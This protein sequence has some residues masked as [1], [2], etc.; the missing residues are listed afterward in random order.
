MQRPVAPHAITA[1]HM[2]PPLPASLQ[3]LSGWRRQS[4]GC[5]HQWRVR[6]Q[7]QVRCCR[8]SQRQ[9]FGPACLATVLQ[10]CCP[11]LSLPGSMPVG[12]RRLLL[13]FPMLP[14]VPG[15]VATASRS[16]LQIS[17]DG[18]AAQVRWLALRVLW[19]QVRLAGRAALSSLT[20]P[21]ACKPAAPQL[22]AAT[23]LAPL[24]PPLQFNRTK[25]CVDGCSCKSLQLRGP[26]ALKPHPAGHPPAHPPLVLL[27][28]VRVWVD[29]VP[30][31]GGDHLEGPPSGVA[32]GGSLSPPAS[33]LPETVQASS[34]PATCPCA[35]PPAAWHRLQLRVGAFWPDVQADA[36]QN[37]FQRR[38]AVAT[39]VH[40]SYRARRYD[41]ALFLLDEPS[42]N[43]RVSLAPSECLL[44]CRVCALPTLHCHSCIATP[45]LPL[46]GLPAHEKKRGKVTGGDECCFLQVCLSPRFV[47]GHT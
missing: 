34:A 12:A 6:R 27:P 13:H 43:A 42:S 29:P 23:I 28:A 31:G 44:V 11:M 8:R 16:C 26:A 20:A 15:H 3:A 24:L 39:I 1:Q 21:P 32:G 38:Q 33:M 5:H 17:M 7:G 37:D 45:A 36:A 2:A 22:L 4:A 19:W 40:A 25:R 46:L 41:I 47:W 14:R 9:R 10:F 35:T 18:S 30:R